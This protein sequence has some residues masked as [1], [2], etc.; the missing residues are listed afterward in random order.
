MDLDEVDI[1]FGTSTPQVSLRVDQLSFSGNVGDVSM[2]P[3]LGRILL[4][5]VPL[6]DV[7][8]P[9]GLAPVGTGLVSLFPR[10]RRRAQP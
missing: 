5:D 6:A 7:P 10:L 9:L 1:L 4:S 2:D 8:A 3:P